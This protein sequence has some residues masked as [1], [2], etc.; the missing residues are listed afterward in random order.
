MTN[1]PILSRSD[2][3]LEF[4]WNAPSLFVTAQAWEAEYQAIIELFPEIQAFQGHL[5]DSATVLG[6]AMEAIERLM[7]RVGKIVVY[8]GMES[9]VDAMNQDA[10]AMDSKGNGL[11]GRA[12]SAT[13][14]VDPELLAIGQ[15]TLDQWLRENP[16]LTIYKHY[17]DNLFRLQSHVRSAEVEEVLGNLIDPF[18]S[19]GNTMSMLTNADLVFRPATNS[20]GESVPVTQGNFDHELMFHADRE[21]RRTAYESYSEGHLSVKHALASNLS[22]AVKQ[23]VFNARVRHYPSALEASLFNNNIPVTVFNNLIETFKAHL[24]TWHR[25]WRVKRKALGYSSFQPYDIWAPL[26]KKSP[27]VPYA[28]AVDWISEGLKPLGND[29]VQAVRQG[30]LQDRWVDVYPNQGKRSGAF[31]TGWAGTFPF[32]MMS[33]T[34]NVPSMSTLAHELGHSMHSYLTWQNQ[35]YVYSNYSLF[36]AEVASNFNQAMVRAHLLAQ[37][38]DPD[39]QLAVIDEAMDNFHRY[40]FIM[41]TLARFELELHQRVERGEGLT[42][43]AMNS[44]LADLFAEGYGGE[45]E[46]NRDHIG[47][48]WAEFGHLYANFYVY[49][50]ATGIAG[51]HA[52]AD[53]VLTGGPDAA[54]DY[55]SFLKSGS[56]VYPLDALKLAG[57]DLTT[58]EPV[59]KAFGVLAGMVDRLEQLTG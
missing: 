40:F 17:L 57:V 44:L 6:D 34:D 47:I 43:D 32:I 11:F 15:T 56:S 4:T 41:P 21:L 13:S 16:R 25:Y 38:P 10:V 35:P 5:A 19:V 14:F 7:R 45:V 18:Y 9:N 33:Y 46:G 23:D 42:A 1:V 30:C 37:N 28:Q 8:T 52:L 36:V 54:T 27:V 22:V 24:P 39:F 29:Y 48:R 50:Y 59:E 31:S 26:A 58:P 12:I 49:Q 55:L 51:A 3:P 2:I 53:R 20:A